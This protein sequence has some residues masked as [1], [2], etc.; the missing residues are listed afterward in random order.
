LTFQFEKEIKEHED[1]L[2]DDDRDPL[3]KA[4]EKV[5]EAAKGDDHESIKSVID[6]L[7]QA[8]MAF[9]KM[10]YEKTESAPAAEDAAAEESSGDAAEAAGE[11]DAIDAEFEVKDS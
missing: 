3:N 8:R 9:G 10:V 5:R 7:E 1:K 6:E 11:D 2:T 4:I